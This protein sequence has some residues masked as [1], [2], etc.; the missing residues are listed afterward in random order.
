MSYNKVLEALK[1]NNIAIVPTDTIYGLCCNAL[2]E[3]ATK[4]LFY[5][6]QR[7]ITKTIAIAVKDKNEIY[8]YTQNIC[9]IAKKIIDVFLPGPLTVILETNGKIKNNFLIHNN[10]IA[11]R[12]PENR[13]LLYLLQNIDFPLALTSA[14]IHNNTNCTNIAQVLKQLTDKLEYIDD[15]ECKYKQ[16]S[17]IIS[18]QDNKISIQREGVIKKETLLHYTSQLYS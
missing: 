2:N 10:T 12:I 4:K 9:P 8:N 5:I 14:N 6:K 16:E 1:T 17:T 11:I 18:F 3:D 15:G 13:K 7:P